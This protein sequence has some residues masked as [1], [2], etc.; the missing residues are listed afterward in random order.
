[1]HTRMVY[2]NVIIYVM[3]IILHKHERRLWEITIFKLQQ[4][5]KFQENHT[6]IFESDCYKPTTKWKIKKKWHIAYWKSNERKVVEEM[7]N[8]QKI[9]I[10]K[11]G[12]GNRRL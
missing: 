7:N 9:L 10:P 2:Y 12:D 3:H 8:Q 5:E 4:I 6:L 11:K 1:M